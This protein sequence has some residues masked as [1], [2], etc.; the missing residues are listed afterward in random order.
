MNNSGGLKHR[1]FLE[2]FN[3]QNAQ[4]HRLA[5]PQAMQEPEAYPPGYV[6]DSC[7]TRTPPAVL[8]SIL[9]GAG[10]A[11]VQIPVLPVQPRVAQLMGENV[12][13]AS[14]R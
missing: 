7:E 5:R 10:F 3:E 6:E 4:K 13:A 12:A 8:F 11:V 2:W 9:S 14:D 1:G